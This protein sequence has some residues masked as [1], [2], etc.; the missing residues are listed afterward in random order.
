MVYSDVIVG[1]AISR[2]SF[3]FSQ[4]RVKSRGYSWLVIYIKGIF[5]VLRFRFVWNDCELPYKPSNYHPKV[6]ATGK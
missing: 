4:S 5:T 2:G 3:V 1:I 6:T